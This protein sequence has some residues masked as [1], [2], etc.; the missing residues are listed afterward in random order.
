MVVDSFDGQTLGQEQLLNKK[1]SFFSWVLVNIV[2]NKAYKIFKARVAQNN[3][4]SVAAS[5]SLELSNYEPLV[6]REKLR[7]SGAGRLSVEYNAS[8]NLK[9]KGTVNAQLASDKSDGSVSAEFL[10]KNHRAKLAL[11]YPLA[12]QL[13]ATGQHGDWVWGLD[14]NYDQAAKRLT[15]YNLLGG[16][17]KD[18]CR[19]MFKHVG[20]DKT[21]YAFGDWIYSYYHKI[22]FATTLGACVTVSWP[23]KETYIEFGGVHQYGDGLVLRGKIDSKGILAAGLTRMYSQ[24]LRISVAAQVDAKKVAATGVSDYQLGVR[25]D[26]SV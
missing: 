25:L 23:T 15:T 13:T 14:F 26:F 9:L 4:G 10:H 3:D 1:Y 11:K 20:L 22:S 2:T 18:N 7:G 16:W 24:E 12:A 5:S 6:I 21:K 8:D 19:L 17:S